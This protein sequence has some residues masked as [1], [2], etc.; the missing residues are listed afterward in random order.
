MTHLFARTTLSL[1]M[2]ILCGVVFHAPISM[3]LGM[4][5]PEPQIEIKAWK[6]ILL[7][8]VAVLVIVQVAQ[9]HV[10]RQL[11]GDWVI[12]ITFLYGAV[13]IL[14]LPFTWQ[15]VVPTLAGLL[16][17][18]RF[19]LMF[20]VMYVVAVLY[21]S[22]RRPL[23]V[24][25]IV[26]AAVSILFALLQVAVLPNDIL[27]HIGYSNQTIA[28]YLTVDQNYNYI[29][30]NGTLRGPNPL[31]L[32]AAMVM[33][34]CGAAL[35][36][37]WS[38]PAQW[39]KSVRGLIALLGMAA[40]VAL[41]FSYSRSA[42][43]AAV[44]AVII[45]AIVRFGRTVSREVW[46]ALFASGLLFA[47]GLYVV[48]DTS[49]VSHVILHEDPDEGNSINSNDGHIESLIDGTE[50]ML[51]QPFGAGIGSTGSPSLMGEQGLIIENHYLYIA[52]EVGWL[53]LILFGV[54]FSRVLW[55]LWQRR[56]DWLALSLLA[57]GIGIAVAGLFLPVWA[58][59]TIALVWW[60]LA[61]LVIG[62]MM[63]ER[64]GS[65]EIK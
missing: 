16:I 42:L 8:I 45:V 55:R 23:L 20:L 57:S 48:K 38:Q 56:G 41:W 44:L 47:G 7:A 61:G 2:I 15:G 32:Y 53:G 24:G 40:V 1:L 54:L 26:A 10:W 39:Y 46:I 50:R 49:F 6:E 34:A 27:V 33:T 18:L 58:D 17:D 43:I 12:K 51:R 13:H 59:D 14:L 65:H 60:G 35:I 5:W 31:G 25:A 36:M 11:W 52:H 63:P 19:V 62:R 64:R 30:I 21:P 22:W 9:R 3:W 28:P 29:R 4:V 37:M